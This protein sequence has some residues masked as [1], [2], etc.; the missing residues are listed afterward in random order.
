MDSEVL[1]YIHLESF[2][3]ILLSYT[4]CFPSLLRK[5]D[6]YWR[7]QRLGVLTA[8]VRVVFRPWSP[9]LTP[10]HIELS[11][12]NSAFLFPEATFLLFTPAWVCSALLPV[13]GHRP[14]AAAGPGVQP[15]AKACYSLLVVVFQRTW[16]CVWIQVPHSLLSGD[17]VMLMWSVQSY[18]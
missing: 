4:C 1:T 18:P 6:T 10:G 3:I 5:S 7:P 2:I 9:A 8:A 12:W 15:S 14:M 16:V 11:S 13:L 17:H